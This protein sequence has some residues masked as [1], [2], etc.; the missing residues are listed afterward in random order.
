ML[1]S[2][3]L[4]PI[5]RLETTDSA[6]RTL[7]KTSLGKERFLQVHAL[8]FVC[9][10]S[11]Q[12]FGGSPS[13]FELLLPK[14]FNHYCKSIITH[15]LPVDWSIFWYYYFYDRN[16][17][18]VVRSWSNFS[19]YLHFFKNGPTL[20][21]LCVLFFCCAKFHK[22]QAEKLWDIL[23]MGYILCVNLRLEFIKQLFGCLQESLYHLLFSRVLSPN[24]WNQVD[25]SDFETHE[26]IWIG[27][28][29]THYWALH[30]F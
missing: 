3:F 23:Y 28:S 27:Q 8:I 2:N 16:E 22:N 6:G 19:S 12:Y 20:C 9:V 15:R 14:Q 18:H 11:T 10:G 4:W 24:L 1:N 30:C 7:S 17:N 29:K 5:L 13:L 25:L 21:L 26:N